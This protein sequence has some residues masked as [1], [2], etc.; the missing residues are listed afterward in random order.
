[1][2]GIFLLSLAGPEYIKVRFRSP[3]A[4]CFSYSHVLY[5]RKKHIYFLLGCFFLKNTKQ[6]HFKQTLQK[7]GEIS[8][9]T[10]VVNSGV[11]WVL[12]AVK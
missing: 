2:V 11:I 9:E 6:K 4:Y 8:N 3:F 1:M 12:I 7:M 5:Q 10:T